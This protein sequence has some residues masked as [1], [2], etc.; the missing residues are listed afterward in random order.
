MIFF[1]KL[2]VILHIGREGYL[3]AS[4]FWGLV[5]PGMILKKKS[6]YVS[7]YF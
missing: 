5:R 1:S 4:E 6:K 3:E 7:F 2:F